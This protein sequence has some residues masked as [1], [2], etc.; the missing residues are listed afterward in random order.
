MVFYTA[1]ELGSIHTMGY[2]T[3]III[4]TAFTCIY[5]V[6]CAVTTSSLCSTLYV[7]V[8]V[9]SIL[10]TVYV[11]YYMYT[12]YSTVYMYIQYCIQYITYTVYVVILHT[13]YVQY[14]MYTVYSTVYMTLYMYMHTVYNIHCICSILHTCS[15]VIWLCFLKMSLFI[16]SI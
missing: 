5:R 15:I 2:H 13:V 10:H 11:Q 6:S 8:H 4:F 9:C 12:V 14:Y 1:E 3:R 16:H 7:H